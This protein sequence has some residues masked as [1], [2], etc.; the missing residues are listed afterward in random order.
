MTIAPIPMHPLDELYQACRKYP[1][2]IDALADRMGTTRAMLYNKLRQG[3]RSHYIHFDDEL[4]EILF[5]LQETKVPDATRALEAIC[6]RHGMLAI[7]APGSN[8]EGVEQKQALKLLGEQLK[9]NAEAMTSF[10]DAIEDG[11][12]TANEMIR[13][14]ASFATAWRSMWQILSAARSAHAGQNTAENHG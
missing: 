14:E 3:V 8:V 2:G 5:C 6:W 9:T 13:I 1:G 7:P 4:S 10:T 11:K 12:I